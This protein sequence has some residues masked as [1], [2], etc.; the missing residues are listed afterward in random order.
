MINPIEP[1]EEVTVRETDTTSKE[2]H[3]DSHRESKHR[4]QHKHTHRHKHTD[5]TDHKDHKHSHKHTH[6]KH[7]HHSRSRSIDTV[8]SSPSDSWTHEIEETLMLW[9]EEALGYIY[10]HQNSAQYYMWWH[11]VL[12][13]FS[14]LLGAVAGIGGLLV[15]TY[16][17]KWPVLVFGSVGLVA[18]AITAIDDRL[19]L[20]SE[21]ARHDASASSYMAMPK[22]IQAELQKNPSGRENADVFLESVEQVFT[23]AQ[24]NSPKPLEKYVRR[25]LVLRKNYPDR[26][27]PMFSMIYLT[28]SYMGATTSSHHDTTV[29][30]REARSTPHL[31]CR[32][33]HFAVERTPTESKISAARKNRFS[34]EAKYSQ[35]MSRD[36]A[37][38][39]NKLPGGSGNSLDVDPASYIIANYNA[40]ESV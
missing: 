15:E 2:K 7:N 22:N 3:R 20:S 10:I 37:I 34:I 9:Y 28:H 40:K 14:I 24:V 21:G 26:K 6:H 12:V 19:A 13:I 25:W 23:N 39:P 16:D 38:L 8:V 35:V 1:I 27:N 29:S 30:L 31:G 18:A 11:R 5:H 17:V 32:R 33:E 36:P 4:D